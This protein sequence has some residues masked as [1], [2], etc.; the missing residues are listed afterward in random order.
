[1]NFF[2][3]EPN[4]YQLF[5]ISMGAGVVLAVVIVACIWFG[6]WLCEKA[7]REP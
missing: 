1:M 6:D 5:F 2:G 4:L 3:R 7:R